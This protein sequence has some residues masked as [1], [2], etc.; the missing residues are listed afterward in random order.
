MALTRR[1]AL[2]TLAGASAFALLPLDLTAPLGAEP[3]PEDMAVNSLLAKLPRVQQMLLDGMLIPQ[4]AHVPED[5]EVMVG[6]LG[7]ALTE[8]AAEHPDWE[9]NTAAT[10]QKLR[11]AYGARPVVA[12]AFYDYSTDNI[13]IVAFERRDFGSAKTLHDIKERSI[14]A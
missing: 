11:R 4:N 6:S 10:I 14:P 3:L 13:L 12:N 8:A 2:A 9:E 5:S 7:F 1:E